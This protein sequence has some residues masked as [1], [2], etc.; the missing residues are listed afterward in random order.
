MGLR[1]LIRRAMVEK[2]AGCRNLNAGLGRTE[3]QPIT[4]M[5]D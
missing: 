4:S 5:S 1:Q 3:A 2:Q